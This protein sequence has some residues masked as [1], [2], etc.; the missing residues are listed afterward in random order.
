MLTERDCVILDNNCASWGK[1]SKPVKADLGTEATKSHG[2]RQLTEY[3]GDWT[4]THDI[5]PVTNKYKIIPQG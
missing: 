2:R 5:H 3:L 4:I 1:Q